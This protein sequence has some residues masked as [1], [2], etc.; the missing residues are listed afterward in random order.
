MDAA[1][2]VTELDPDFEPYRGPLQVLHSGPAREPGMS[3]PHVPGHT[4]T[5]A[6]TRGP[7]DTAVSCSC[8]PRGDY[9]G[10]A[11]VLPAREA[12]RLWREHVEQASAGGPA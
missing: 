5:M 9:L 8:R 10:T 7:Q 1:L 6:I 11:A 3:A 4:M 12:H 2:C